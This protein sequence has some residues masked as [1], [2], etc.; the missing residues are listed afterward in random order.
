MIKKQIKKKYNILD[1]KSSVIF[2]LTAKKGRL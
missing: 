1:N 2:F